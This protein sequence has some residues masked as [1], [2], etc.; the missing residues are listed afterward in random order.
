M[1]AVR[2]L[3]VRYGDATA[4][5]GVSLDL[6]ADQFAAVLG[7]N[8]A[9][10]SSLAK[11]IA[12]LIPSSGEL[13]LDG[14]DISRLPSDRLV[15]QGVVY[16]PEGRRVFG[17]ASVE[18]NLR[19]GAYTRRQSH[20]WRERLTEIYDWIPRLKERAHVKA[21]LLSGGEQQLLAIGR[22]LMARPR[23]MILDEPSL[24]LSPRAIDNVVAFLRDVAAAE[25]LSVL[26]CEQNTSFASR[27]A[28]RA[29]ALQLGRLGE[30]V[31]K[32]VIED[33]TAL[34]RLVMGADG[35]R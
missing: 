18:D 2:N 9:G 23:L 27:L 14:Q 12:R 20:P 25:S 29:W 5:S 33:P 35:H 32:D 21:E 22:G 10:K 7:A 8:G 31:G 30:P 17:Q 19:A 34:V 1:L 6:E 16:V 28:D 3:S 4:L 15:R 13:L 24:G 26:I 11:A